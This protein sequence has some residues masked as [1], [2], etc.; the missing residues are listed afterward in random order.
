MT[1]EPPENIRDLVEGA[2]FCSLGTVRPDGSPQV[3]PM[4]FE[5][6]GEFVKMTHTTK[7]GKWRNLQANPNVSVAI[8]DPQRPYRY[9]EMRGV[10]DHTEPDPT[11]GFYVHLSSLYGPPSDPPPDRADRVILY[12]R[13]Q[14]WSGNMTRLDT[15]D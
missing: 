13:P 6:D 3:N 9:V 1:V 7:R 14:K 12:L 5:W 8:M 10:L 11:G 15:G 4:W 2:H